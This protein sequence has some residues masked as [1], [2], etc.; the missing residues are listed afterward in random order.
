MTYVHQTYVEQISELAETYRKTCSAS[1]LFYCAEGQPH[2]L[3]IECI[4]IMKEFLD[5]V[6]DG[7]GEPEEADLNSV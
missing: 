4:T 7:S 2:G 1:A 3:R 5:N 6:K